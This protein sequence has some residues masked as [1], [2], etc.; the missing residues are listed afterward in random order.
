MDDLTRF[1]I[2]RGH[3]RLLRWRL[4][5]GGECVAASTRAFTRKG[6]CEISINLARRGLDAPV[7][8][9]DGRPCSVRAP[10]PS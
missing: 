9:L 6:L 10:S 2:I 8:D 4:R 3:S 1:E 5:V 7:I